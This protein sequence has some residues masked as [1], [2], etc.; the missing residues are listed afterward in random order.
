MKK[1]LRHTISYARFTSLRDLAK[2]T[3]GTTDNIYLFELNALLE[4]YKNINNKIKDIEVKII[5]EY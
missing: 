2:N 4:I 3:V 1:K 5:E